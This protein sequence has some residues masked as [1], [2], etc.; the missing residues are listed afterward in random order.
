MGGG[1][2]GVMSGRGAAN[3]MTR[4][5]SILGGMFFLTSIGLTILAG[6]AARPDGSIMQDGQTKDGLPTKSIDLGPA[7]SATNAVVPPATGGIPASAPQAAQP[8]P[9]PVAPSPFGP[10]PAAAP[11]QPAPADAKAA[12]AEDKK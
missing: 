5:T 3:F 1:P 10:A 2:S 4:T 9:E 7:P 12:P 11:A 8:A 6:Q